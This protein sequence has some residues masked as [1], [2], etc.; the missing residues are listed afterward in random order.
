MN[1]YNGLIGLGFKN[2]TDFYLRDDGEGVYIEE[3]FSTETQPSG[4][5]IEVGEARFIAKQEAIE[6][7]RASAMSKL[8]N[9][10]G[11]TLEEVRTFLTIEGPPEEEE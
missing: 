7:I 9:K 11:L 2:I 5:D 6:A 8:V 1:I 3:W 10:V 4:A